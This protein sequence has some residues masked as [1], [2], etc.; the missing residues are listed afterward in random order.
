[1]NDEIKL[2]QFY[3]ELEKIRFEDKFEFEFDIANNITPGTLEIPS[4][5]LHP[6]VENAINHGLVHREDSGVLS[7]KFTKE[8]NKLNCRIQDNGI[9]RKRAEEIKSRSIK[10]YKSRGMQ[11]VQERQ[12]IWNEIGNS[13]ISIHIE[14]LYDNNKLG[15]G[16]IVDVSIDL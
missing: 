15:I 10:S 4:M 6:F 9:G 2:L 16:T 5:L 13:K 3:V 8:N 1:M 11:L 7:I 14:D 12:K